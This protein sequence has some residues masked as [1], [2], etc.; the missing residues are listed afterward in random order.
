MDDPVTM[1]LNDMFTIPGLDGGPAGISVPAGLDKDGLPLGLQLIGRA[2][3]EETM[4]RPPRR[5]RRRQASRDARRAISVL[6]PKFVGLM[7]EAFSCP[8]GVIPS[9]ARDPI[10]IS[11]DPSLRSG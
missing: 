10:P 4:L 3:D 6:I 7:E 11:I 2:F 5:S 1:Y 9:A 8:L